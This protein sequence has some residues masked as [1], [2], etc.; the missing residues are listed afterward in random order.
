M[1]PSNMVIPSINTNGPNRN[2]ERRLGGVNS[3]FAQGFLAIVLFSLTVPMTKLALEAFSAEMIA[4]SRSFGAGVLALAVIVTSGWRKPNR[5]ECMWMAVAGIGVVIGFPYLLALTL[6]Q[7]SATSM[8]IILAGLP[9]ATSIAAV[10]LLRERY[11]KIFW[12]CA[13]LGA[14]LLVS[15]YLK[16]VE[17]GSAGSGSGSEYAPLT[18]ALLAIA[19]LLLGG[20]GYACGTKVAKTLG[21]W[22]TICWVLVL[23]LPLST[24]GFMYCISAQPLVFVGNSLAAAS[25]LLPV[26]ALFYLLLISQCFGFKF[27]YHAMAVVGAGSISQLQLVQPFFTLAF[28]AWLLNETLRPEAILYVLLILSCLAVAMKYK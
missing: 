4:A 26:L 11:S 10:I 28:S 5:S 15:Y 9:L 8:G 13:F 23:Y 19:T 20:L 18:L 22:Q 21:G 1:R 24:L 25:S 16:N 3:A 12:L 14:G 6:G 2:C 27:W 17:L 7:L